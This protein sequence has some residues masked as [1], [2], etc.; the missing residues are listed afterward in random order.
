MCFLFFLSFINQEAI[1]SYLKSNIIWVGKQLSKQFLHGWVKNLQSTQYIDYSE[2]DLLASNI[3]ADVKAIAKGVSSSL[4][5]L[6]CRS[7]D[8]LAQ[9][10]VS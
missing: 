7:L 4:F 9:T 5:T 3:Q 6:I 1:T 8:T 10:F 2:E